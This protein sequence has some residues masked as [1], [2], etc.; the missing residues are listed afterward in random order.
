MEEKLT[1]F[2]IIFT[3]HFEIKIE[4]IKVTKMVL[5]IQEVWF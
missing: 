3:H 1:I 2:L 5:S 4:N